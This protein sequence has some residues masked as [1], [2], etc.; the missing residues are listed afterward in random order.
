M[1]NKIVELLKRIKEKEEIYDKVYNEL[2]R[3]GS[4]PGIFYDL[5]KIH[6]SIVDGVPPFCPIFSPVGNPIYKLAKSFVPLLEPI[7]QY[8]VKDSF[9]VL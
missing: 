4:K 5:C 9:F 6:K 1:E 2:Y 8:T 7:N 3:T